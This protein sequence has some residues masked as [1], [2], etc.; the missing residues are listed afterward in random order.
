MTN[1]MSAFYFDKL[2]FEPIKC[3]TENMVKLT[4]KDK[5]PYELPRDY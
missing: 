1:K 3:I 4:V 2:T 5:I